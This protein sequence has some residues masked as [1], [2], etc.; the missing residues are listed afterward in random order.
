MIIRDKLPLSGP[1]QIT[2]YQ[3]IKNH[4]FV[5]LLVLSNKYLYKYYFVNDLLI[6][7]AVGHVSGRRKPHP[8]KN[9]SVRY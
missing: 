9:T 1:F 2:D 5:P 8:T 4:D 7:P 3:I 6:K